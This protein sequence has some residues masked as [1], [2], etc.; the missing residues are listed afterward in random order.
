V[1][2]AVLAV[3][4]AVAVC[5]AA[6][7][8]KDA[9][10]TALRALRAPSPGWLGAA[11]V[12]EVASMGCY[13][14]MQRR[15]LRGAGTTVPLHR[16][17]ALAYAAHSMSITLPGGPLVSTVYNYRRMRGFGADS[18]VA[19]W[20]TAA[21]GVLSTL[22]LG[23]LTVAVGL[24]AAVDDTEDVLPV[25][26]LLAA[27][28]ALA[29]GGRLLRRRPELTAALRRTLRTRVGRRLPAGARAR[30]AEVGGWLGR[31][32][33]VRIPPRDLAVA[34][35]F[36]VANWLADALCLALC[37]RALGV[38]VDVVPLGLTYIAGMTAS[39]LPIVPGGLGT[40][41]GALALGLVTAGTAT[42][43]ALAVVVLYRLLSL[44]LIGAVGWVLWLAGR[45]TDAGT[46]ETLRTEAVRTGTSR[47]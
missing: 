11:L 18:T 33:R 3:A 23:V 40:V 16:A 2:R 12:A 35:L 42:S 8:E 27:L 39:S 47:G 25:A 15:L 38:S 31:L 29:A 28:V 26:L 13:A 30:L 1:V 14:R 17:V 43:P 32:L 7:V 9:V 44:V 20:C 36:S 34:S 5:V 45:R 37:C 21:S 41:D 22:G 4:V 10:L 19:A 6:V 24:A 46:R